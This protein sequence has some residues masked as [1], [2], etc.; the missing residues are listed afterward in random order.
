MISKNDGRWKQ[1]LNF[2]VIPSD[3]QIDFAEVKFEDFF[4]FMMQI[5]NFKI[6]I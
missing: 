5:K 2:V 4:K 1:L 6:N 3:I